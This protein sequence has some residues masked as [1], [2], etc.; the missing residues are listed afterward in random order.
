[1]PIITETVER[2]I[3]AKE[4]QVVVEE[5]IKCS[6]CGETFYDMEDAQIHYGETHA[7]KAKVRLDLYTN[8][9]IY[10]RDVVYLMTQED[11]TAYHASYRTYG[12]RQGAPRWNGPGWYVAYV[13]DRPCGRGCCSDEVVH[14]DPLGEII[15]ATNARIRALE[16]TVLTAKLQLQKVP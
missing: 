4:A 15:E 8:G 16:T 5:T 1:M 6:D 12:D 2:E 11:Y 9:G 14:L 3:P 13:I 7:V 10:G